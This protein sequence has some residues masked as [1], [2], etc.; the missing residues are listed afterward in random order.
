MPLIGF[1]V[2]TWVAR[3]IWESPMWEVAEDMALSLFAIFVAIKI[4][5]DSKKSNVEKKACS[6]LIE[7][8]SFMSK[9]NMAKKHPFRNA[10]IMGWLT[11]CAAL[12]LMV[13]AALKI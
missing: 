13:H 1:V 4:I 9:P 7:Q 12:Y 11:G 5:Q 3:F 10:E 2:F 8:I 6:K